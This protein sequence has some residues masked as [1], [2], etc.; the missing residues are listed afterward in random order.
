MQDKKNWYNVFILLLIV[1]ISLLGCKGRETTDDLLDLKMVAENEAPREE[2]TEPYLEAQAFVYV[3][4]AVLVPGVYELTSAGRIYEAIEMAGGVTPEAAPEFLNQARIVV[5]GERIY[6]PTREEVSQEGGQSTVL[7]DEVHSTGSSESG[8]VNINHAGLE[9]L[10]T[11]TGIGEAKARN[12]INYR[13]QNGS[14]QSLEDLMRV[15]GI[16]EGTFQKI[17]DSITIH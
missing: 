10:Q 1:V 2:E 17:V 8:K 13:E 12:I 6:V 15:E 3:C 4:G 14:F 16:K 5:D 9:E 7:F 11:L